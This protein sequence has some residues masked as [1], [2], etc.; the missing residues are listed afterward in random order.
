M[1]DLFEMIDLF[2]MTNLIEMIV[3][4]VIIDMML[5]SQPSCM[6]SQLAQ[7]GYLIV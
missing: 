7:E 4:I 6:T 5:D 1:T 2:E 3:L